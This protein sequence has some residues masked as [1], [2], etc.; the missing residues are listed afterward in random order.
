MQAGI[1]FSTG[2]VLVTL[3]G[4]L[5]NDPADIPMLLD[6][7]DEG[8]DVVMGLRANRQDHLFIRKIPS[9]LGNWLIR[10][11]TGVAQPRAVLEQPQEVPGPV[12]LP[13][14]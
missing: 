2:D 1:D 6:R 12:R 4:D 10:K 9:Q 8:Y 3:D 7:L 14:F 11:V 13:V 5:Q